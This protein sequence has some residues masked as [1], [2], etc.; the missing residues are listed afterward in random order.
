MSLSL[1]QAQWLIHFMRSLPGQAPPESH[2]GAYEEAMAAQHAQAQAQS[3]AAA[4]ELPWEGWQ[5]GTEGTEF[6]PY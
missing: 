3:H 1:S 6:N 4:G 5:D 2:P